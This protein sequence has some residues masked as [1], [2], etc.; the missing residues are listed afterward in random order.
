MAFT[1]SDALKIGPLSRARVL[2]GMEG[3]QRPLSYV[4]VMEVPDILKWVRSDELLL[5]TLYPMRDMTISPREL[6]RELSRRNLAGIAVKIGRYV[7]TVPDEMIEAAQSERLP[8][9]ELQPDIS[10]NDVINSL[11]GEILNAQ[12]RTLQLSQEIHQRFT[13]IVLAGGG[14][15]EIAENLAILVHSPIVIIAP[16]RRVLASSEPSNSDGLLSRLITQKGERQHLESSEL[17][18]NG[19]VTK[20]ATTT[21]RILR[22]GAESINCAVRPIRV[23]ATLYGSIIVILREQEPDAGISMAIDHAATVAALDIMKQQAVLN[24]ERRFQADFLDDLLSGRLHSR[25][26]I[27]TRASALAWNLDQPALVLV[28]E[29]QRTGNDSPQRWRNH[30]SYRRDGMRLIDVAGASLLKYDRSAILWERSDSLVAVLTEPC[31]PHQPQSAHLASMQIAQQVGQELRALGGD[32]CASIGVGRPCN[33]PLK[34]YISYE[35]A[36][37]ALIIGTKVW[38]QGAITH[39]EDLGVYRILHHHHDKAELDAFAEEMLGKLIE[40]DRKRNTDLVETLDVLMDCNLNISV[41]ARRL[42][43]HYNSLR[44]RLQKIEELIGPFVDD[45]QQR[46]NLQFALRIRKARKL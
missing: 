1:V 28:I 33:D 25:E 6:V 15:N 30:A 24:V 34:L 14:L 12:A 22:V 36:R 10:F 11:L 21:R 41:A 3:L 26:A 29:V 17:A 23:G 40:Y 44:Y 31:A 32:A 46:F 42:Y 37:Q 9:L 7:D 38:G 27:F 4:N 13:E 8:L 35:E 43:L 19:R 18:E 45:A 2:A 5:T 16:D 39:F 20:T